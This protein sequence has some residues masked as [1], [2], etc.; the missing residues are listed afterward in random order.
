MRKYPATGVA[1]I[2]TNLVGLCLGELPDVGKVGRLMLR[3]QLAW[4]EN[5]WKWWGDESEVPGFVP[6]AEIPSHESELY[7]LGS[8]KVNIFTVSKIID[9][10]DV[11]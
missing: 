1:T 5:G 7:E 6:D 3:M 2:E 11:T 4:I 8:L 10:G 9:S